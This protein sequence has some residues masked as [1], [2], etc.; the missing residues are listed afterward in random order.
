[1]LRSL[2]E[3]SLRSHALIAALLGVFDAFGGLVEDSVCGALFERLLS[4]L[5]VMSVLT[6]QRRHERESR[7]WPYR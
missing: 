3:P 2:D 1:M 4:F 6:I 7:C 5:A